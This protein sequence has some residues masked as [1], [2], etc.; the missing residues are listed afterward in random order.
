[1]SK[2]KDMWDFSDTQRHQIL[3]LAVALKCIHTSWHVLP[4]KWAS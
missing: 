2:N 3:T 1:V 4:N